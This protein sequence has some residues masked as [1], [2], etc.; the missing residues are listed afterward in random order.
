MIGTN[1]LGSNTPSQIAGG[2][3]AIVEELNHKRPHTRILLLGVF[4]RSPSET[5]PLR[6][7]IKEINQIISNLDDGGK[8]VKYLDIGRSFLHENG[9]LT[10]DIMPDYLHLSARGYEIWAQAILP[11]LTQLMAQ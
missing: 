4:P 6:A 5:N 1:N 10:K 2:I 7:K 8:T 11:T 9:T 3:K